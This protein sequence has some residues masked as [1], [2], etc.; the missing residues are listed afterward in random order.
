M[1]FSKQSNSKPKKNSSMATNRAKSAGSIKGNCFH[2]GEHGHW[3]SSCYLKEVTCVKGCSSNMKLFWSSKQGSYNCRFLKCLNLRCKAFKW[4]DNPYLCNSSNEECSSVD[5][6]SSSYI[7][8]GEQ[9]PKKNNI[10]I[11]VEE[12]G[13]KISLEGEVDVVMDVM[14]K[15]FKM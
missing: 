3:V 5:D 1:C 6:S 14:K 8:G 11:T 7:N 13:K 2:C 9:V 10:K 12:N 4:V 15:Q